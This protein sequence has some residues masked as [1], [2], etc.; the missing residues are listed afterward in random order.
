[1]GGAFSKIQ[2]WLNAGLSFFYPE[3]CQVCKESRATPAEGFVCGRSEE[4]TS[5]LQSLTN[6][7]CRLLLEKKNMVACAKAADA[8]VPEFASI[9]FLTVS[10]IG[11]CVGLVVALRGNWTPERSICRRFVPC[12]TC[13]SV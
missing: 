9:R 1:M 10:F 8:N 13:L 3:I 12:L 11:F 6:V 2:T 5:E 4:H 7:V